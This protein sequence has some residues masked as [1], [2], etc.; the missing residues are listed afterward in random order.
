LEQQARQV[1]G[2][3]KHGPIVPSPASAGNQKAE[4]LMCL[5]GENAPNVIKF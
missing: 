5:G 3:G 4:G 2:F 1:G